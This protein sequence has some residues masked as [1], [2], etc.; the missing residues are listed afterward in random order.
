MRKEVIQYSISD[1]EKITGIKAHTIRVWERRYNLIEPQRTETNIRFYC[2]KEMQKLL[3][4]VLLYNQGLKISQIAA[5]TQKEREEMMA[6]LSEQDN[7]IELRKDCMIAS[8]L[9]FNEEKF[10]TIFDN[11]ENQFGLIDAL[12][13]FIWPFIEN[14]SLLYVSGAFNLAHENF[15]QQIIKRRLQARVDQIS[16]SECEKGQVLRFLPQGENQVLYTATMEYACRRAGYKTINLG[17]NIGFEELEMI[18][19]NVELDLV[20]TVLDTEFKEMAVVPYIQKIKSIFPDSQLVVS[21][22]QAYHRT[23]ESIQH[24]IVLRSTADVVD[25]FIDS[26]KN[27]L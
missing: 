12:K 6:E 13:K 5:M 17:R 7:A 11:Y 23:Y 16:S 24:V 27:E 15:I 8:V 26:S 2:Q 25:M 3:D 18:A 20:L 19:E 4:V 10:L 1:L 9:E 21:G 22:Y 14:T